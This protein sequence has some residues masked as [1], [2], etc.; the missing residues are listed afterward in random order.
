MGK[1]KLFLCLGITVLVFV[2]FLLCKS[3]N[4]VPFLTK[5]TQKL[6]INQSNTVRTFVKHFIVWSVTLWVLPVQLQWCLI[7]N[8]NISAV[9][10]YER[11]LPHLVLWFKFHSLLRHR[12]VRQILDTVQWRKAM[13]SFIWRK[14]TKQVE[15]KDK[16]ADILSDLK[17][18]CIC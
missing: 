10:P 4:L 1:Y 3:R 6:Y 18:N 7:Q 14:S 15:Q 2:L 8:R 12:F 13:K 5:L 11:R 9:N 16:K 17:Y